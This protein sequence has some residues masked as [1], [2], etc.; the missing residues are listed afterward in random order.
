MVPTARDA[1]QPD[2]RKLALVARH[3]VNA[4]ILTDAEWRVEW[5]NDAFLRFFGYS[6]DEIRGRRP[7]EFLHGPHTSH[8]TLAAIDD[9]CAR[10][11]PFQGEMLNYTKTG[12]ARW[13][14]LDIQPIK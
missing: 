1:I 4:V 3:T 5:A 12:E 11:E 2:A 9:A 7:G 13:V 6:F 14:E 8:E 10:G